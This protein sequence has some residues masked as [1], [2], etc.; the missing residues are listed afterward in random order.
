MSELEN[1]TIE[2]TQCEEKREKRLE[3]NDENLGNV[4]L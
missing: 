1:R 3:K 4:M 2:I